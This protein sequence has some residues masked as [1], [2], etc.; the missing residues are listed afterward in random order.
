[1]NTIL[2]MIRQLTGMPDYGQ[3]LAH[4]RDRHPAEP[5]LTER[6]FYDRFLATRYGG[7]GSRCC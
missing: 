4:Q 1:M 6:E 7:P 2:R 5:V 3:Y